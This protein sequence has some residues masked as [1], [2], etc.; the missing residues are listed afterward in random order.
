MQDFNLQDRMTWKRKKEQHYP[1]LSICF[2][3]LMS[4]SPI[5]FSRAVERLIFLIALIARL[6]ILIAR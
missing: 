5:A 2:L 3:Y 6:I 1:S 4:H